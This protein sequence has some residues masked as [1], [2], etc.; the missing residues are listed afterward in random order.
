M[1]KTVLPAL[2]FLARTAL[3]TTAE[4][5]K[6][7]LARNGL[8]PNLAICDAFLRGEKRMGLL[9]NANSLTQDGRDAL[10][11]LRAL[12]ADVRALFSPEHGPNAD[13]EG[14]I[15]S[16]A[17]G[18][19]PVYSL[20]GK[21][22]RPTPEMLDGLD[23]IC[24]DLQDVGARFYT[25]S[26][27]LFHV[28]EECAK[29][30]VA[31]VV[32]DRPNPL[33]DAVEG[34]IIES[35]CFSF[36]GYAPLPIT[37]GMTMGE[38]A[39]F[40]VA[41]RGLDVELHVVPIENHDRKTLWPQTE[42]VWR[43]PSPNLPDFR[44]AIWYPGLCLLEFC[45]FAVGR[46]TDAPFQILAAPTLDTKRFLA[47]W[48]NFAGVQARAEIARPAHAKFEGKL[49]HAIRFGRENSELAPENVV[50]FGFAVM[51]TLA[52][53]QEN[54][55]RESW[56]KS[57]QLIGSKDVVEALWNGDL[58]SVLARSRADAAQFREIRAPFLLY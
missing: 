30:G 16:G 38:L 54:L 20:Y 47:H 46:G 14:E 21:T 28:L 42:L 13:R 52:R 48:E 5:Q 6:N 7:G 1:L 10:A 25:Y 56:D 22:R 23:A 49:C 41:W 29:S 57:A 35:D 37:H 18:A 2:D 32:F 33:G 43:R 58:E 55:E 9:Y 51:A 31:V 39:R 27:T 19:L 3:E 26:S 24:V 40:F 50:E 34:P 17:L 11:V 44:A 15:E 4:R 8:A 45:D 53:S 36:I 12:G